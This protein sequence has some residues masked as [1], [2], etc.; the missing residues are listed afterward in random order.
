LLGSSEVIL[1]KG[2]V[3]GADYGKV[4]G[5]C[6]MMLPVDHLVQLRLNS[7]GAIPSVQG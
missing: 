6:L 7:C 1:E 5:H 2:V 3:L 4:V